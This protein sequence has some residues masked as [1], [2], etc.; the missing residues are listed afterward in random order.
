M[1]DLLVRSILLG[2]VCWVGLAEAEVAVVLNSGEGTISLVDKNGY[3]E[4]KKIHVGREPHH[5]MSLPDNSA[6]LVANSVSNDLVF[7]DPTSGQIKSRLPNISDPYQLAFSADKK[8]FATTSLRLD[9]VDIYQ[10]DG[11]KLDMRFSLPLTPSHLVFDPNNHFLFVTLQGS[12]QLAA[13]DLLARKIAWVIPVGKTPAGVVMSPD[14]HS[15]LVGI[16][17]EDYVAVVDWQNHRVVQKI[18]TGKGAHNLFS[19]GDGHR[20]LVSNRVA[21]TVSILNVNTMKVENTFAVPGGPDCME[22]SA[23]RKELWVTSRW[24]RQVSVIDM[25][26]F[27]LAHVIPVGRSPH[28]IFFASHVP[29]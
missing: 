25:Q 8:W 12:D 24:L 17:G 22:L 29:R 14:G 15:L 27:K 21:N 6:L 28:G 2:M 16:M 18:H 13:I 7:L 1:R 9:R 4:I 11:F 3:Q 23:D 10:A 19:M 26:T 5:L 20:F